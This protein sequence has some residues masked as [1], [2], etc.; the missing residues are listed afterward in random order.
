MKIKLGIGPM[1]KE[2]INCLSSF[3]KKYKTEIILIASRNQIDIKN[4]GGGYVNNFDTKNYANFIKNKKNNYLIM[5]RDHCG[6]YTNSNVRQTN[7]L[8][9]EIDNTKK[10]LLSD[11][12]NDFKIIH[13]DTS[14][15]PKKLK[16]KIAEELINYCNTIAKKL[17]KKIQ[18]EFGCE[19]HGLLRSINDFK[20]DLIFLK[21]FNNV[22][23]IVCQTGSLVKSIFQIG[24]FDYKKIPIMKKLALKQGIKL[25]E[26]NCDY[27]NIDQIKLRKLYNID[28]INIAPEF[29]FMQSLLTLRLCKEYKI[30]EFEKFFKLVIREKK[31][32]KWI[33]KNENNEIK[34]LSAA[35]YHFNTKQYKKIILKIGKKIDFE[36]KLNSIVTSRLKEYL[37]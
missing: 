4:F 6:P 7:S 22:K 23:F 32:K 9:K 13:I 30:E 12:K 14:K 31:W 20:K 2:I 21:K 28:A 11:I 37:V 17:Q 34:F 1:S 18:F 26:H 8:K 27:L 5:A 24:Q 36:K 35:H 19:E 16:Y 29:G 25:K 10:T 3:S 33:Y 15:V